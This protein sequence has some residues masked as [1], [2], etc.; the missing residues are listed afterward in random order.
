MADLFDI[1]LGAKLAGNG[2]GGGSS[3]TLLHE[4]DI[5]VTYSSTSQTVVKTITVSG[6]Y[7]AD[8]IIYVRIRDKAGV[9][10]GYFIE[11]NAYF[12][13]SNA[14]NGATTTTQ[15][16]GGWSVSLKTGNVFSASNYAYG[17][18]AS[19][20]YSDNKIDIAARYSSTYTATINGTYHIAIYKMKLPD[21]SATP[22]D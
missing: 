10:L 3:Y 20:V 7:T 17:L 4:E 5:D 9:R 16:T 11:S 1:A 14:K 12:V 8:D 19:N 2:G 21:G 22:F 13:N 6:A 18:Y 15:T